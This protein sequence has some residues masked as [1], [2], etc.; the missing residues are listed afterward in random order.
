MPSIVSL[1]VADLARPRPTGSTNMTSARPR[2]SAA[3]DIAG[4]G[5]P[6]IRQAKQTRPMSNSP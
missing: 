1:R 6:S 4:A 3:P 5:P 2:Q